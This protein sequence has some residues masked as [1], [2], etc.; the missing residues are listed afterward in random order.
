MLLTEMLNI[1]ADTPV[2]L[3]EVRVDGWGKTLTFT[4]RAGELRFV[5]QCDDCREM[6]WRTYAHAEADQPTAVIEFKPGRDQHRSPAH[7]LTD[8]FGLSLF[9]GALTITPRP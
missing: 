1:A 2:T 5:L 8:H 7:L 6:R 3:D 4:G 9:Y